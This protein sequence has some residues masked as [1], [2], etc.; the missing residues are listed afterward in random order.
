MM[1]PEDNK[2]R[3]FTLVEL[4]VVVLIVGILAAVAMPLFQGRIDKSKWSEA[5]AA[6]GTIR[7]AVRA[8]WAEKGG[9][10]YSGDYT[11]ELGGGIG[12][13]GP[14]IGINASDLTGTYFHSGCYS[15]DSVNAST[16]LCVIKI[17]AT[18]DPGPGGSPTSPSSKT[19]EEDG[20]LD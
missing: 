4:M 12:V 1:Y 8:Y 20:T 17:D 19:M 13:F 3:G 7:T 5:D 14:K 9:G 10:T 15:I 11:G 18:L 16:G 2:L 6:A